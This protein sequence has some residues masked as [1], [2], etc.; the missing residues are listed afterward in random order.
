[1]TFEES[2]SATA[3]FYVFHFIIR[4]SGL[5]IN[6]NRSLLLMPE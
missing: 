2:H 1:M 3:P 5:I 4:I 6:A